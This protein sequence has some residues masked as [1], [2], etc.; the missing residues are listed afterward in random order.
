MSNYYDIL[1]SVLEAISSIDGF[2]IY[3]HEAFTFFLK[4]KNELNVAN[5]FDRY[6]QIRNK[7]NYYGKEISIEETKENTQDI[8]K[9]IE[10]LIGKYMGE[11]K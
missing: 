7:I 6:R 10:Y 1:R 4:D 3:S 9:I 2:K 8:E 11:V 5:K